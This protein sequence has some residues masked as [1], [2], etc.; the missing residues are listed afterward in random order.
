MKRKVYFIEG[1][2]I[3][4]EVW[5]AGRPVLDRAVELAFGDGR[6][7]EWVELL[8]VVK[9]LAIAA[10][11]EEITEDDVLDILQRDSDAAPRAVPAA[12]A[13]EIHDTVACIL[14]EPRTSTALAAQ[15]LSLSDE[16]M[17]DFATRIR[18]ETAVWAKVIRERKIEPQL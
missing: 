14:H 11:E 13:E 4:R 10:L 1:D 17:A 7:F 12:L 6:G 18:T 15:G 8:A 5:A 2:G 3:G 16:S 9:N